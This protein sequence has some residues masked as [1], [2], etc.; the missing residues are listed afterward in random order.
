MF[1]NNVLVIIEVNEPNKASDI[2][3]ITIGSTDNT[4]SD[5]EFAS[6]AVATFK[7]EK[8]YSDE[9]TFSV[10]DV[11]KFDSQETYINYFENQLSD[12]IASLK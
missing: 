12:Y 6:Q 3:Y 1:T 9:T 5:S 7:A 2:R 11:L 10:K 8:N 4:K